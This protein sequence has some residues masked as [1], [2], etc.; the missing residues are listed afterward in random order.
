M[1]GDKLARELL[2][3]AVDDPGVPAAVKLQAIR[4]ALSRIGI[5]EQ[6]ALSVEVGL[7]PGYEALL[8][9]MMGGSRAESRARRGDN[10][11]STTPQWLTDELGLIDAEVVEDE[12]AAGHTAVSSPVPTP[13]ASAPVGLQTMEDALDQLHHASPQPARKAHRR[14][15]S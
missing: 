14:W 5:T 3:I 9:D 10:D 2:K 12:D 15:R 4:D 13:Y 11:P 7:T 6:R 8:G 1:A